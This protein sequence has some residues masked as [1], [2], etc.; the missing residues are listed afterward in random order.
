MAII[1]RDNQIGGQASSGTNTAT[2]TVDVKQG[3]LIV[4]FAFI[5]DQPDATITIADEDSN[6]YTKL[7][8]DSEWYNSSQSHA[9]SR[10]A[11]TTVGA[12]NFTL[13]ITATFGSGT[14]WNQRRIDAVVFNPGGGTW[15]KAASDLTAASYTTSRETSSISATEDNVVGVAHFLNAGNK[16]ITERLIGGNAPD[17]YQG[18]TFNE[19]WWTIY[20]S[21]AT[22]KTAKGTI[23]ESTWIQIEL[24]LFEVV[25]AGGISIPVV[26]K[27]LREQRI[28]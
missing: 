19:Q 22:S 15:N 8:G 6:T 23:S 18:S 2:V 7:H 16:T 3:D 17:T 12:D 28:A 25:S 24:T 10:S 14:G 27:H 9:R 1:V 5:D 26:M 20:G 21:G 4:V 11:Y 13:T